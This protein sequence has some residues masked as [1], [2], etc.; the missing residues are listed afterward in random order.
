MGYHVMEYVERMVRKTCIAALI[1]LLMLILM[2]QAQSRRS[3]AAVMLAR[4]SGPWSAEFSLTR[5][6]GE[7]AV[8]LGAQK[9]AFPWGMALDKRD[10]NFWRM[11]GED[12]FEVTASDGSRF[13]GT[14]QG[15]AA[16]TSGGLL[17]EI[18]TENPE[19]ATV[20]GASVG[21]SME[22]VLAL[23]PEAS[24]EH[25]AHREAGCYRYT[26]SGAAD[27]LAGISRIAFNF[28]RDALTSIDIFHASK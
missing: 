10:A 23:Y 1:G 24:A 19:W 15:G 14:R 5:D 25:D 11:G 8:K 27:K 21:M 26:Y 16:D 18:R 17:L 20:R 12:F 3:A 28:E 2:G 9:G 13:S 7:E 4:D 6:D 22:E